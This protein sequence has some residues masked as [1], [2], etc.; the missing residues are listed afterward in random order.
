MLKWK[1]RRLKKESFCC[2]VKED[3]HDSPVGIWPSL[4]P[5]PGLTQRRVPLYAK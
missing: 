5:F 1:V 3:G 2:G 4:N